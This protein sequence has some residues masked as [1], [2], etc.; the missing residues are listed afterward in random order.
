MTH[1]D[2]HVAQGVRRGPPR[3]A[4]T[5]F[6][7]AAFLALWA[8]LAAWLVSRGCRALDEG[9]GRWVELAN[10]ATWPWGWPELC[11]MD[12]GSFM[13]ALAARTLLN[14]AGPLLVVLSGIWFLTGGLERLVAMTQAQ[15]LRQLSSQLV[16]ELYTVVRSR[17]GD[18]TDEAM[19]AEMQEMH[20]VASEVVNE[21]LDHL[22]VDQ[23]V[24]R[25][26]LMRG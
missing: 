2:S 19:R 11:S 12:P 18:T 24:A 7:V 20:A 4:R 10:G 8:A 1:P 26:P 5:V 3:A 14:F 21:Y 22:G 16:A 6:L 25:R 13:L 23:A 15:Q 17:R 9:I